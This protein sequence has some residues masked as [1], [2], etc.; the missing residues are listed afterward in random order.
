MSQAGGLDP[1]QPVDPA[2]PLDHDDPAVQPPNVAVTFLKER[3]Y[4]TFTGLAIVLTLYN[5]ADHHSA[6]YAFEI[7][8]MGVLAV[9]LAGFASDGIAHLSVHRHFPRGNEIRTLLR[10]A[11][12]ALETLVV[13]IGL[14]VAAWIGIL[15]LDT[16]LLIAG[17]VYIGTL[18]LTGWLA[19]R[20]A[21][22]TWWQKLAA[23]ITLV[24]IGLIVLSVQ[25][26]AHS[27]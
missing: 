9:I 6:A 5:G 15:E 12:H 10:I 14:I 26:F 17:F 24:V 13:P 21:E 2:Q 18:G 20:N 8:S 11:G 23:L 1:A 25:V 4:A 7:L 3:V 19:V 27:H 22:V 16:A